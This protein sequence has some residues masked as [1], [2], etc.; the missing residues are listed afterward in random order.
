[1][2]S[3]F[4]SA[5]PCTRPMR[6]P[7]R[8]AACSGSDRSAASTA[9]VR[10]QSATLRA[11]GPIEF[12]RERERI[13]AVARDAL[14]GR[15]V[16]D[17]AAQGG[18]NAR[19]AAGVG[20]DGDLADAVG[21]GDRAA[22]GRAAG[23]ALAVGRIA[24]RAEMRIGADAGERE[25]GHVGLGDD[26]RAGIAQALDRR[27]IGRGRLAALG[28]HR[29]ACARHL[30]RDVEQV[31]DGDDRAVE[32]TEQLAGLCAR[33]GGVGSSARGVGIDG[34]TGSLALAGRIGDAG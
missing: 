13:G 23:N 22:G 11:I 2:P 24:R 26:H 20:A 19:R 33:I 21:A 32:R 3:M 7:L 16:A 18:R 15:L 31:L 25:L 34:E 30:A 28:Q 8:L 17:D 1:M 14:C 27:R 12:E 29:R 10:K 4:S 9:S 6:T 5:M